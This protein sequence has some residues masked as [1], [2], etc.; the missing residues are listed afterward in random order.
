MDE[1]HVKGSHYFLENIGK[2]IHW[3]LY[4]IV[5]DQGRG[6][7]TMFFRTQCKQGFHLN[8]F[9]FYPNPQSILESSPG[10][11]SD[12]FCQHL[13]LFTMKRRKRPINNKNALHGNST[14]FEVFLRIFE[15]HVRPSLSGKIFWVAFSIHFGPLFFSSFP[16][17]HVV[18]LYTSSTQSFFH[19]CYFLLP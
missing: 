10:L 16:I 8:C 15:P 5:N 19:Y 11:C 9:M 2:N 13:L 3:L 7:S 18:L 6:N 14:L 4:N 12:V 17:I 1:I